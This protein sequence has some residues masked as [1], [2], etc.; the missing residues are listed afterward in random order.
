MDRLRALG[1][2]PRLL[3]TVALALRAR[4]VRESFA[5]FAREALGRSGLFH[6]RL[7]ESGLRVALRHRTGDVVTL[8][9]VWHNRDYDPPPEVMAV[10][11]ASPRVLD[12]GGNI[13]LF[14]LHAAAIW[15]DATLTSYEP[16]AVNAAVA[17]ESRRLN[18]LEGHWS[19]IEAAAGNHEGAVQFV[20]GQ[21]ALSHVVEGDDD[22]PGAITVP[23]QDVLAE[24]AGSDLVKMDIEGGEWAVLTDNRFVAHPPKAL[25]LEYHP[26]SSCPGPDPH[27][28]VR[29][30]LA[31]AGMRHAEVWRRDDGHGQMWA[32]RA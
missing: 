4:C 29:A 25:V 15:P 9:E 27:E 20:A 7:R 2:H 31:A 13:G 8:G 32:W 24:V 26:S 30:Q 22:A 14:A 28:A 17:R 1:N 5:F 10:L 6:Y 11:G 19:I 16:D 18:H 3:P 23:M 21:D 12:L